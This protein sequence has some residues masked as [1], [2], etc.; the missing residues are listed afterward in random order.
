VFGLW[1]IYFD[2]VARHVSFRRPR[3]SRV[4]SLLWTYAHLPLVSAIA[5][6]SAGAVNLLSA[7]RGTA[8]SGSSWLI[9]GAVATA[10]VFI[11]VI[12]LT[13]RRE[14]DEPTDLRV[15]V[16]LK[17]A[18][19]AAALAIGAAGARLGP[20]AL[21]AALLLPLIVQMGYGAYVWFK[22]PAR[23]AAPRGEAD[24]FG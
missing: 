14:P 6:V 21:Q 24:A 19:A 2:F 16:G 20:T 4:W 7:R 22:T 5:A 18:G 15:S 13:L 11:G 17:L 3:P 10:L 23:H 1:W 8:D 12:E 9:A